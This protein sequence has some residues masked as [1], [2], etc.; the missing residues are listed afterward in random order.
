MGKKRLIED[1]EE[2]AELEPS[3]DESAA[4]AERKARR[5]AEKKA[6]KRASEAAAAAAAIEATAADEDVLRAATQTTGTIT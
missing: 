6:A 4:K 1:V 5:K 2:A 3:S